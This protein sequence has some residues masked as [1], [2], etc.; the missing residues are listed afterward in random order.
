MNVVLR[1]A[2]VA[3]IGLVIGCATQ[4]FYTK[5]NL[6][7]VSV[8]LSKEQVMA[9]FP[10]EHSTGGAPGMQIRS[11]RRSQSGVL[12]EVGELLMTDG[13]SSRPAKYWFFF[14][15][16]RLVRWVGV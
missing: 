2:T 5:E 3:L 10:G 7:R 8:G 4:R 14:E 15:D 1:F 13:V 6:N 11:A 9:M 16:G 12:E